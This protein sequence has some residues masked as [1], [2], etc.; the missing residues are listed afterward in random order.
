[1]ENRGSRKTKRETGRRTS[2]CP[3]TL[4]TQPATA[5]SDLPVAMQRRCMQLQL[6]GQGIAPDYDL[7]EKLRVKTEKKVAVAVA[8][9]A[10]DFSRRRSRQ[11][12][13]APTDVGGYLRYAVRDRFGVV[14]VRGKAVEA[15]RSGSTQ[16]K[17]QGRAGEVV[18]GG[19]RVSWRVSSRTGDKRAKSAVRCE[20]FDADRV[21]SPVVLRHWRPGDRFQPIGMVH[22]VKLQDF[23]TNQKVLRDQ[24]RRLIVA[25]TAAG[26]LFWVEG[27]RIS[28][29]FKLTGGTI[30]C[31]QWRWKRL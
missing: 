25:A 5:F 18:F 24:R 26:A 10:A 15:F 31:L 4:N 30:R 1:M 3:S 23:F 20:C 22:T 9:A 11:R 29:R 27:M 2:S 21:G 8:G 13:N 14:R 19:V 12:K 6:V 28:E 17:L 7:V 16:V